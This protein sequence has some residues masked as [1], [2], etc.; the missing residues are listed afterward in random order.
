M[1]QAAPSTTVEA[2]VSGAPTGLV[3]TIG[4]RIMD[5]QGG[6]SVAR[7]TSGIVESPGGSGIYTATLTAP[8][9]AGQYVVAWD[10]GGGSPTWAAED[11]LV[12]VGPTPGVP[13]TGWRPDYTDLATMKGYL[14]VSG[15]ADD[16]VLQAAIS[17]ASR[18]IDQHTGRQ[19][20]KLA[21]PEARYYALRMDRRNGRVIVPI[22][23]LM[24]TTG[25]AI[26]ADNSGSGTF[27]QALTEGT[28]VRLWPYNAATQGLPYTRIVAGV[29]TL[30]ATGFQPF[31]D[32]VVQITASWGWSAVP[33]AISEACKIQAGRLFKRRDAPFGVAGSPELGSELRLLAKV[34]PDVEVLCDPYRRVWGVR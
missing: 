25:L 32:R 1:I 3:G 14:R 2:T 22:D 19:F 24:D 6:T 12:A 29:T 33:P 10:T 26:A 30:V 5:G 15:T 34:D 4:V 8:T 16:A 28:D 31:P 17:A 20:G 18:A 23:D 9:Q 13:G 27:S 21:A 11:L 7:T